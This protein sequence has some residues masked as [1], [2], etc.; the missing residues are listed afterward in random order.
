[1]GTG[2]AEA[3]EAGADAGRLPMM[4]R[5]IRCARKGVGWISRVR[6]GPEPAPAVRW[7]PIART[8]ASAGRSGASCRPTRLRAR[9]ASTSRRHD[10]TGAAQNAARQAEIEQTA[11]DRG[12]LDWE[13]LQ[14]NTV[15]LPTSAYTAAQPETAT[16]DANLVE[17]FAAFPVAHS[18]VSRACQTLVKPPF[19]LRMRG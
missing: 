17:L 5:R 12:A 18:A 16:G 10:P 14:P 8:K 1:M 9:R 2:N 4:T 7:R 6:L 3:G 19:D 15:S 13:R 11:S